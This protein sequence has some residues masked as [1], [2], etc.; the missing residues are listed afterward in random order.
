MLRTANDQPRKTTKLILLSFPS[1]KY[2]VDV[3]IESV[4]DSV[5]IFRV[6]LGAK[7]YEAHH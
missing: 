3:S 4:Y 5:L 6:I 1:I 7:T 2:D